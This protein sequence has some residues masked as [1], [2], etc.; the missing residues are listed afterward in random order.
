MPRSIQTRHS[1]VAAAGYFGA[2]LGPDGGIHELERNYPAPR[3]VGFPAR[4]T[5]RLGLTWRPPLARQARYN[6][7]TYGLE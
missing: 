1:I 6:P 5:R 7:A 3:M 4:R 2:H